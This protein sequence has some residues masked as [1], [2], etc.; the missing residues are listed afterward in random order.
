MSASRTN[1][2]EL[3]APEDDEHAK[4][5]ATAEHR[6]AAGSRKGEEQLLAAASQDP[7]AGNG[8]RSPAQE[9]SETSLTNTAC[10]AIGVNDHQRHPKARP[11]SRSKSNENIAMPGTNK[12]AS[13][14]A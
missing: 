1:P 6:P 4:D 9:A 10:V 14:G 5:M 13:A 2:G 11:R 3:L 8:A 12:T 7:A